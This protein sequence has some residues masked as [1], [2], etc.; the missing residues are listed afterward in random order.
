MDQSMSEF[1]GP[2]IMPVTILGK[3]E[4]HEMN[5]VLAMRID[6]FVDDYIGSHVSLEINLS[7]DRF[8]YHLIL[9]YRSRHRF[10]SSFS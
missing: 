5:G 9:L 1:G 3:F 7:F 6:P 10:S 8:L 2:D 4:E